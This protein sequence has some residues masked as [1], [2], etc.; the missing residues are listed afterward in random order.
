M[1]SVVAITKRLPDASVIKLENS[2][3]SLNNGIEIVMFPINIFQRPHC[4]S[5]FGSNVANVLN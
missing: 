5:T 2:F 3:A 1:K 4:G